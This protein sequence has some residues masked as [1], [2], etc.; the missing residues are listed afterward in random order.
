MYSTDEFHSDKTISCPTAVGKECTFDKGNKFFRQHPQQPTHETPL[1]GSENSSAN[2]V[3]F[4]IQKFP[5]M[6]YPFSAYSGYCL[7]VFDFCFFSCNIQIFLQNRKFRVQWKL[8]SRIFPAMK[9]PLS[10]HSGY[11]LHVVDFCFLTSKF[12][13]KTGNFMYSGNS[14]HDYV[15]IDMFLLVRRPSLSSD[16]HLEDQ[17]KQI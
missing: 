17:S 11:C 6:E 4:Q 10:A 7:H 15:Y 3:S 14:G 12:S 5:A 8:W 9:Q 2:A 1:P 16:C 13:F